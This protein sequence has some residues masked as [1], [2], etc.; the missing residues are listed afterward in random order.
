MPR[1]PA[2]HSA[3]RGV[4]S[5]ASAGDGLRCRARRFCGG[6]DHHHAGRQGGC[7]LSHPAGEA[8]V[9]QQ[10]EQRDGSVATRRARRFS[11]RAGDDR[12][13]VPIR[14]NVT[15][16]EHR[17]HAADRP[18]AVH[19]GRRRISRFRRARACRRSV[20][21]ARQRRSRELRRGIRQHVRQAPSL[22]Q[23]VATGRSDGHHRHM[24]G[25]LRP[26]ARLAQDLDPCCGERDRASTRYGRACGRGWTAAQSRAR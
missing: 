5:R 10:G 22:S 21:Q 15:A 11:G 1:A 12:R 17:S 24:V 14:V 26:A 8:N 13:A 20:A 18:R 4:R 25:R 2:Q 3:F 19:A 23:R 6:R 7:G 9:S 16:S